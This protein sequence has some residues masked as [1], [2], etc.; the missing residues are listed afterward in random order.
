MPHRSAGE[1]EAG[2]VIFPGQCLA[3]DGIEIVVP[4]L[5]A[6]RGA[7]FSRGG[8]DAGWIAGAARD[9]PH[10]EAFALRRREASRLYLTFAA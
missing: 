2:E 9:K 7:D 6:E 1:F 5:P 3:D 10:V 8:N 4:G